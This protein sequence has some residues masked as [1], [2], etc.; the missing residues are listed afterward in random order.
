M[1]LFLTVLLGDVVS[2]ALAPYLPESAG[3][4]SERIDAKI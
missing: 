1:R 2:F 3:T 4:V